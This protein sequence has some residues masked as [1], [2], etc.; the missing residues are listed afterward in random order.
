M[1]NKYQKTQF[2]STPKTLE[3]HGGKVELSLEATFPEKYFAKQAT[4]DFT[5]VL[6][7]DNWED[8][9][10]YADHYDYQV[11][12]LDYKLVTHDPD[13]ENYLGFDYRT[14]KQLNVNYQD[15]NSIHY[16]L[17]N[18]PKWEIQH[19]R[20]YSSS[21]MEDFPYYRSFDKLVEQCKSMGKYQINDRIFNAWI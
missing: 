10:L 3:A 14:F 15:I 18:I 13:R 6:I 21:D 8:K 9:V 11:D 1:A 12:N 5:P 20:F 19:D 7:Y 4:V 17:H 2:I 16:W